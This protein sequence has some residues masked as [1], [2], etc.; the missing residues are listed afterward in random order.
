MVCLRDGRVEEVSLDE[1]TAGQKLV[2]PLGEL[3]ATARAVGVG[4]GDEGSARGETST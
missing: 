4:F 1:A 3:V 2:D